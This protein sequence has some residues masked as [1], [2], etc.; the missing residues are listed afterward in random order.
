MSQYKIQLPETQEISFAHG[1][2]A[3]IAYDSNGNGLTDLVLMT[4]EQD[5]PNNL[6]L[7]QQIEPGKLRKTNALEGY[8]ADDPIIKTE[9]VNFKGGFFKKSTV[10]FNGKEYPS[11]DILAFQDTEMKVIT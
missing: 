1:S 10:E 5:G 8:E 7:F 3:S 4:W 9:D 6:F 2:R 11:E